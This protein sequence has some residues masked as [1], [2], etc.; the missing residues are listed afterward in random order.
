M[1]S[2]IFHSWPHNW[3]LKR[4][5]I[6]TTGN[7][8]VITLFLFPSFRPPRHPFPG[9]IEINNSNISLSFYFEITRLPCVV[10]N[11]F[12]SPFAELSVAINRRVS[13]VCAYGRDLAW[14]GFEPRTPKGRD[15]AMADPSNSSCGRGND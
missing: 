2:F 12:L 11:S 3:L 5:S 13:F 8:S 7:Q 15:I 1:C 6:R 10:L 14:L 9:S 4:F